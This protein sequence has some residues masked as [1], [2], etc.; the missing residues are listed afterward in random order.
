MNLLTEAALLSAVQRA[1]EIVTPLDRQNV[2]SDLSNVGLFPT[3]DARP[4]AGVPNMD[5]AF[6]D[7][8]PSSQQPNGDHFIDRGYNPFTGYRDPNTGQ[9]N[10]N[11]G[12]TSQARPGYSTTTTAASTHS[13]G[14]RPYWGYSAEGRQNQQRHQ[15]TSTYGGRRSNAY[16]T[17]NERAVM[18]QNPGYYGSQNNV[19]SD[20]APATEV[21]PDSGLMQSGSYYDQRR[22][23][24][25]TPGYA[26]AGSVEN[27]SEFMESWGNLPWYMHVEA[28][29]AFLGPEFLAGEGMAVGAASGVEAGSAASG[30]MESGLFDVAKE[31]LKRGAAKLMQGA[32]SLGSRFFMAAEAEEVLFDSSNSDSSYHDRHLRENYQLSRPHTAATR[33]DDYSIMPSAMDRQITDGGFNMSKSGGSGWSN[34]EPDSRIN[35]STFG[36]LP[37][38]PL[39]RSGD[40]NLSFQP[41]RTIQHPSFRGPPV[42]SKGR[43]FNQ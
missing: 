15:N 28:L 26:A 9:N 18:Q 6:Y 10:P 38:E 1:S 35:T 34:Q 7:A 8:Q 25:K 2:Y 32:A 31:G 20:T 37:Q 23:A 27:F 29:L 33:A 11:G 24:S 13:S 43:F 19:A 14:S 30:A 3:G 5:A 36:L 40:V 39:E 16:A 41:R 4:L 22:P 21:Q 42:K 12:S 17:E